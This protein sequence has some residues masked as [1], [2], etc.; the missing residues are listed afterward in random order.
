MTKLLKFLALFLL[1]TPVLA[2]SMGPLVQSGTNSRYYVRPDGT[3]VY[4]TGSHTWDDFQDKDTSANPAAF[5]FT[6]YVA[7]LKADG[8]NATIVWNRDSPRECNWNG[9]PPWNLNPQPWIRSTTPGASDGGNKFDLTQFNQAFFD[10]IRARVITLQSNGIYAIVQLFDANDLSFTRCGV[11]SPSGDGFPL[12]GVNNINSV[13]DGYSGSGATG[14]GAYTMANSGTNPNLVAIQDAFVEK[15]V[16]TLND[17]PN[18]IW[19]VA[20]EQPGTNYAGTPGYGGASSMTFWAPH[21]LELL[22]KY[23]GGGTCASCTGTPTFS[24]K[25]FLHPAGIGSMNA[26]DANDATLYASTANWI[27]PTINSN[28]NNQ[29]PCVPAT[30]NQGKIV[31]Q[32]TDHS[33]DASTL[34]VAA[35]GVINDTQAR[36]AVWKTF[37]NGGSGFIFMDPYV[38]SFTAN[39]RNPCASPVNGICPNPMT[40]YDPLRK[41]MGTVNTLMPQ[42]RNLLAMTP[43]AALASTGF[44]L[45]NNTVGGE[46][47]AYAPTG[48][49]FT[50]NLSAQPNRLFQVQWLNPVGGA[51]TTVS[52]L[53]VGGST[54]QS[55]T[56]PWGSTNDAVL[57]L[58]DVG[59]FYPVGWTSVPSTTPSSICPNTAV[60]T[61]INGSE[62]CAAVMNDW[63][64]GILDSKR[65]RLTF[66]GG[67]HA[68]YYG[69]EVYFF[70]PSLKTI[71]RYTD[72][73][74]VSA[75]PGANGTNQCSGTAF[76][77]L[78]WQGTT[79]NIT[80]DYQGQVYLPNVDK[81][82]YTMGDLSRGT[83]NC[84]ASALN[85]TLARFWGSW[86]FNFGTLNFAT[87]PNAAGHWTPLDPLTD[88][89]LAAGPTGSIAFN[90]HPSCI[91]GSGG[92]THLGWGR[93]AIPL[94]EYAS[95]A[96]WPQQ[97]RALVYDQFTMYGYDPNTNVATELAGSGTLNTSSN[98]SVVGDYDPDH[99]LYWM[100]GGGITHRFHGDTFATDNVTTSGCT[101]LLSTPGPGFTYDTTMH[102]FVGWTGGQTVYLFNGSDNPVA[103]TNY[104]TVPALTC[105]PVNPVATNGSFPPTPPAA[106]TNGRFRF[107]PNINGE[108]LFLLCAQMASNCYVLNLNAVSTSGHQS[109]AQ[110]SAATGVVYSNSLDSS[111]L[112]TAG[113]SASSCSSSVFPAFDSATTPVG[114][115]LN[116]S[117]LFTTTAAGPG[118]A[119]MAGSW[120][121][122]FFGPFGPPTH[123]GMLGSTFYVQFRV[124]EDS[125]ETGFAWGASS[126]AGQKDVIFHNGGSTCASIELT[127]QDLF[128]RGYPQMYTNCGST[129]FAVD[130]G[131]GDLLYQQSI[132]QDTT[133]NSTW[134]YNCH[135]NFSSP[136]EC[137]YTHFPNGYSAGWTTRYYKVTFTGEWNTPNNA[138]IQSWISYDKGTVQPDGSVSDGTLKQWMNFTTTLDCNNSP[139]CRAVSSTEGYNHST[140][141]MYET[142]GPPAGAPTNAHRWY[143]GLIVSQK[144]IPAPDGPTPELPLAALG[145]FTNLFLAQGTAGAADGSSCANA[146]AA[147]FFNSSANWGTGANQ[148]G[149]GTTIHLCGTISTVLS[150]PASSGTGLITILC[151]T[152]CKMS[153]PANQNFFIIGNTNAWK[154]NGGFPCGPQP[155]GTVVCNGIIENTANGTDL[156]N[157]VSPVRGFDL[158]GASGAI[159]IVGW[160]I[161]NLYVHTPPVPLT[162]ISS[163]GTNQVTVTCSGPCGKVVGEN[164]LSLTDSNVAAFNIATHSLLVASTSGNTMVLTYPTTIAAAS[165]TTG[166]VSDGI[167]PNTSINGIHSNPVLANLSIHDSDIHDV[168]WA[169]D[170]TPTTATPLGTIIDLFDLDIF[171]MDHGP[172]LGGTNTNSSVIYKLHDSH[173]HSWKNWDTGALNAYHHDGFHFFNSSSQAAELDI[174]NNL[175]DVWDGTNNTAPMF[176]QSSLG[177]TRIFNNVVKCDP[178][179]G[180]TSAPL[181]LHEGGGGVNEL[182][183]NNTFMQSGLVRLTPPFNQSNN[184]CVQQVTGNPTGNI[185]SMNNIITGCT[186]M[187]AVTD[188]VFAAN[189]A[190]TGQDFNVYANRIADGNTEWNW[191]HTLSSIVTNGTS[192]GTLTCTVICGFA[193]GVSVTISSST[194]PP[195]NAIV[196]VATTSGNGMTVTY[197]GIVASGTSTSGKIGQTTNTFSSWQAVSGE[198]ANSQAIA[199]AGI[200]SAGN[201]QSGSAAIGRASNLTSLCV[202]TLAPLCQDSSVGNSRSPVARPTSLPWDVG[203][204]QFTGT[205]GAPIATLSAASVQFF[206]QMA[207]TT[208]SLPSKVTLT[209]TG[210]S[211]LSISS[212]VIVGT[213]FAQ[214]NDCGSTVLAGAF[215]TFTLTFSPASTGPRSSTLSITDGASGSPHIVAL[216][217]NGMK[218]V[219]GTGTI[220]GSGTIKI[221]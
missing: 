97:Q 190:T 112:V 8:H 206:N 79:P 196:T 38:I 71:G 102:L 69:N 18:V 45:A 54:T 170:L 42:L 220:T 118:C 93:D 13:T 202:G 124:L 199:A 106:G 101:V 57:H 24:A 135:R 128:G 7:M 35:T 142:S 144:P 67:G 86:T 133:V 129:G 120:L 217:G 36:Q 123:T 160:D 219:S 78:V 153:A 189:S 126:A 12:T 74:N 215:C 182:F 138:K 58:T 75:T 59:P 11:T 82:L 27:A 147:S 83:N 56:P 125:T 172:T 117:A 114:D 25:P 52:T 60:F 213:E 210:N 149:S 48:G 186:T 175:F 143:S 68:G 46:F 207:G 158:G 16:D 163:N 141:T 174:Y 49:A 155:S 146:L 221:N 90:S 44:A 208:T 1:A 76:Q 31:I 51:L 28:F 195:Q 65:G 154:I 17:L 184:A 121:S 136:N 94:G 37:V 73:A 166:N 191:Q 156:A 127:T 26:N 162:A 211:S 187:V 134:R 96:W 181:A 109:F 212:V 77:N 5:N 20:E 4:L 30:N 29:F 198:G 61:G 122:G 40:K 188:A 87:L 39:N 23:E 159:E 107:L 70:D 63:S 98:P 10:R 183:V 177:N 205:G 103:T 176:N 148:I 113:A 169:V 72:P 115:G 100:I 145:S 55:F 152:G 64:G 32:D 2:Q 193:P 151:E 41:A 180:C 179:Q 43:Q 197:P 130:L 111:G 92:C 88:G 116:G 178:A 119:D 168:S 47:V 9:A 99:Q 171:N 137:S 157:Q 14:V 161:R 80:H 185:T 203:A 216:A 62:G 53:L 167:V 192:G 81:M 218:T 89:S 165:D 34:V 95:T 15:M 204:L 150:T 164:G 6:N 201:L 139:G 19:E 105:V 3:P 209:N 21:I 214:S 84:P 110:R 91:Q 132:P 131:N 173:I 104:G 66:L 194:I 22:Q 108:D 50:V 85:D 33:C 200:D 140:F